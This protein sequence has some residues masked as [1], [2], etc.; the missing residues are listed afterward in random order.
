MLTALVLLAACDTQKPIAPATSTALEASSKAAQI[1]EKL[2]DV[3]P[4]KDAS[5]LDGVLALFASENN[6]SW[7]LFNNVANIKWRDPAPIENGDNAETGITH[8]RSGNILLAGFAMVRVPNGKV[9]V[10][11]D[12]KDDNEGN[13]G[14]TLN[15]SATKVE[16]IAVM[17]FYPSEN[18]QEVIRQQLSKEAQVNLIAE[19]CLLDADVNI[20]NTQKN[21]F[22]LLKLQDGDTLYAEAYMDEEGSKYNPGSTTFVFYRQKPQQRITQMQCHEL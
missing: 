2:N 9:G 19:K 6:A 16:S 5:A 11:A 10:E 22:Y 8:H 12:S 20:K 1:Q 17:K 13:S 4:Q 7:E 21:K 3:Q 18:Y 15:G 14:I